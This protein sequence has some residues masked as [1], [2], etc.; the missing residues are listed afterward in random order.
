MKIS[1]F[2]IAFVFSTYLLS[3]S[4]LSS[5]HGNEKNGD[6]PK[7]P[8]KI[9]IYWNEN[10]GMM[11]QYSQ[12]Y[13]SNDSCSYLSSKQNVRQLVEYA[14]SEEEIRS[15][16][17]VF[18]TNEFNKIQTYQQEIYDRGGSSVSLIVD[19]QSFSVSNSGV[20]FIKEKNKSQYA[21]IE[22]AIFKLNKTYVNRQKRTVFIDL[23]TSITNTKNNVILYVNDNIEYSE[24]KNGEYFTLEIDLLPM[25]NNFQI[26]FMK[27]GNK[28]WQEVNKRFDFLLEQL[29]ENNKIMLTLEGDQL[30]IKLCKEKQ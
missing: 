12:I 16:Y 28:S 1:I 13:I 26:Y 3:C 17:D 14:V 21:T 9:K 30:N 22:K 8:K 25:N 18:Y 11:P 2:S 15:L 27:D 7:S 20:D 4:N 19:D 5:T 23:D 6:L 29:P 24:E 10:G